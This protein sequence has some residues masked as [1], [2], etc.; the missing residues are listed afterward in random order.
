MKFIFAPPFSLNVLYTI[1]DLA[2]R[3][4]VDDDKMLNEDI[5]YDL[6]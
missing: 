3:V 6:A 1:P 4:R 2:H 5:Y